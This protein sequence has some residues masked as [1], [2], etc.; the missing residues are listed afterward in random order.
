MY[1]FIFRIINLFNITE[2]ENN[3]VKLCGNLQFVWA[4]TNCVLIQMLIENF[5]DLIDV[6]DWLFPQSTK[7]R[8]GQQLKSGS[9]V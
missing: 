3:G 2:L 7:I 8:N 6:I 5:L 4:I 9:H 1:I